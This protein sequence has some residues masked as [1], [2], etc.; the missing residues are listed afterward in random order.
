V[1]V[2]DASA[3]AGGTG[4][5]TSPGAAVTAPPAVEVGDPGPVDVRAQAGAAAVAIKCPKCLYE[6]RIKAELSG[7]RLKCPK[8][9][10]TIA[11]PGLSD[12]TPPRAAA[13]AFESGAGVPPVPSFAPDT[14]ESTGGSPAAS[15]LEPHEEPWTTPQWSDDD[16]DFM[17]AFPV[18]AAGLPPAPAANRASVFGEP[19]TASR[20]RRMAGYIIDVLPTLL[21]FPL[22]LIPIIG[23]LIFGIA[24]LVY[25]LLRDIRGA[26]LGKWAMGTEIWWVNGGPARGGRCVM[27]NLTLAIG[28][29]ISMLLG[30]LS[31]LALLI[32]P[33]LPLVAYGGLLVV[34]GINFCVIITEL[35]MLLATGRRIGDRFAGTRVVMRPAAPGQGGL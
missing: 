14:L 3:P 25:W 12:S 5:A 27:R 33:L 17:A 32:P 9:R 15:L 19:Q 29:T 20:L 2:P 4:S 16:D 18:M 24:L 30:L 10:Q 23:P 28:P 7:K 21:L 11:V 26:S 35:I 31:V 34:A 22:P 1:Q 13:E 6:A 8:C